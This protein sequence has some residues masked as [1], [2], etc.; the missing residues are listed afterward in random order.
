MPLL[1]FWIAVFCGMVII[2]VQE[3]KKYYG[4]LNDQNQDESAKIKIEK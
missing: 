3:G 2:V 4:N 1:I